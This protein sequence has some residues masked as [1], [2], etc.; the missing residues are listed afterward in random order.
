VSDR[1]YR[2]G[3]PEVRGAVFGWRPGQAACV[4]LGAVA[5]VSLCNLGGPAATSVGVGVLLAGMLAAV[6]PV[7]GRGADQWAPIT[8]AFLLGR[9]RGP[10]CAGVAVD[11][12]VIA[13]REVGCLT[14][15]DGRRTVVLALQA[16]GLRALGDEPQ[17]PGEAIAAWLRGLAGAGAPPC[18][19]TMLTV[20]RRAARAGDAPWMDPGCEVRSFIA[21]TSVSPHT[22]MQG[23]EEAVH[24]GAR[25]LGAGEVATLLEERLEPAFGDLLGADLRQRWRLVEGPA[26]VHAAFVVEEWP[27][28]DVDEQVLTPLCVGPDRRTV[29]IALHVEEL[30]RSRQRTARLRTTA[31]AD[32]ALADRGGFLASAESARNAARDTERA[33]ELA[34][35]HGSVRMAGVIG[36]DAPDPASLEAAAS[37]L[38]ADAGACGARLRRCDGDHRRGLAA[39]IP[40]WCVP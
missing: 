24:H 21:V 7:R 23:L 35:G 11:V 2:L 18:T 19:V 27:T 17:A 10:W 31:A 30:H 26:T 36:I 33:A 13:E 32:D 3:R 29:A 39:T 12:L 38:L 5:C 37:R 22:S 28:G 9:R 6:L 40:G 1:A 16:R 34:A 4:A 15:P 20:T 14:W 8:A 25:L